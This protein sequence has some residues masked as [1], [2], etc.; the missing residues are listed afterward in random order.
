MASLPFSPHPPPDTASVASHGSVVGDASSQQPWAE[1]VLESLQIN[2]RSPGVCEDILGWPVFRPDFDRAHIEPLI[3][4]PLQAV[5]TLSRTPRA[6]TSFGT[7][8]GI[9]EERAPSLVETFLVNVHIKNPVLD[10]DELRR[11]ANDIAEVGF[12]WDAD[13]C[14]LVLPPQPMI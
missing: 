7:S 5:G 2:G 9:D 3:F 1:T 12:G 10:P 11:K 13:S 6:N 8:L 4:N 14:L